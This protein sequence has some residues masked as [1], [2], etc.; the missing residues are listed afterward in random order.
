MLLHISFLIYI[1]FIFYSFIYYLYI[2]I[3]VSHG[4]TNPHFLHCVN[5]LFVFIF[6]LS[7][8]LSTFS[9]YFFIL[10]NDNDNGAW[11]VLI[12]HSCGFPWLF[13]RRCCSFR[14]WDPHLQISAHCA[15]NEI[16][17]L[18]VGPGWFLL[19]F[20]AL[21]FLCASWYTMWFCLCLFAGP[22]S[23]AR[24]KMLAVVALPR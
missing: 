3:T 9:F 18:F 11:E 14:V 8:L 13:A 20:S 12:P 4:G 24:K 6:S 7:L 21:L 15:C 2:K 19:G 1:L 23:P 10:D 5:V 16:F 22:K 17:A